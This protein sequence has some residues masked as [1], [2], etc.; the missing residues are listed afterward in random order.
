MPVSAKPWNSYRQIATQTAPP[1]QLVLML[2]DGAIRFLERSLAGF[3]Y[4]DPGERNFTIHNNIQRSVEIIRELRYSLN[5]E[6]GGD[7]AETLRKLYGYFER[8][9]NE[10]NLGKRR[11]G[12]DEV[13]GH[14]KELREAWAGMLAN[15]GQ[16]PLEPVPSGTWDNP[17]LRA[18]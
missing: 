10:S 6:A 18:A 14:L 17:D 7:L 16:P 15:Q 9:L 4:T 3:S 11:D 12:I 5:I 13:I 1:G 8:R 2:F